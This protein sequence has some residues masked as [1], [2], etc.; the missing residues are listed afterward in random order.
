[1]LR[2][3]SGQSLI[4]YLIIVALMAVATM[5]IVR[6]MGQTVSAKFATITHAL[7]GRSQSVRTDRIEQTHHK[8]KDLGDFFQ[9]SANHCRDRV[10]KRLSHLPFGS[11]K[12][13]R[14]DPQAEASAVFEITPQH[15]FEV[16]QRLPQELR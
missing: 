6:V 1:M 15:K 2:N 9:G 3:N 11:V 8:S 14:L 13:L 5:G 10:R 12:K 4:E 7:Q 16:K